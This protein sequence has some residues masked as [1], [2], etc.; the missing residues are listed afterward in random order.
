[1]GNWIT[2]TDCKHNII[3]LLDNN[4]KVEFKRG[5]NI[6]VGTLTGISRTTEGFKFIIWTRSK[7]TFHKDEI[8][9]IEGE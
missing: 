5:G 7:L 9:I 2:V 3:N 4:T 1:M 6:R 8:R